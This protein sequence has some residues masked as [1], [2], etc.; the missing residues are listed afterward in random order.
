VDDPME[1]TNEQ[2]ADLYQ[3]VN[4]EWIQ[5]N[6]ES[7]YIRDPENDKP[8]KRIMNFGNNLKHRETDINAPLEIPQENEQASQDKEKGKKTKQTA[9]K[10]GNYRS[11]TSI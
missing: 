2:G 11:Y 9:T 1:I 5:W 8:L 6:P 3:T 10:R 7:G 4:Y